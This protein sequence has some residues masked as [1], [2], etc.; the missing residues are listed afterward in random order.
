M[1][2]IVLTGWELGIWA[3]LYA[4]FI[5]FL[6]QRLNSCIEKDITKKSLT[7][8]GKEESIF[9]FIVIVLV[10]LCCDFIGIYPRKYEAPVSFLVAL[11]SVHKSYFWDLMR[12]HEDRNCL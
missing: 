9:S 4:V 10:S 3:K 7:L 5:R 2:L 8:R 12:D 11:C 6:V 1:G